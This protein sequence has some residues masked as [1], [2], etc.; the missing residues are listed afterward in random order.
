MGWAIGSDM[1]IKIVVVI[2]A[3]NIPYEVKKS[4]YSELIPIF[5][6]YD[7]D[8]LEAVLCEDDA[9]DAAFEEVG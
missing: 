6:D 4:I 9:F 7:F 5:K 2:K 8:T 3:H 1:I